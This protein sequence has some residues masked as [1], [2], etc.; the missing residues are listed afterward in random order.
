M[1]FF[2]FHDWINLLKKPTLQDNT[3]KQTSNSGL[4]TLFSCEC[5]LWIVNF[6]SK[7]TK[8]ENKKEIMQ[9]LLLSAKG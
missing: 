3:V 8:K 5:E 7:T 4:W 1:N 6:F 9:A 2:C